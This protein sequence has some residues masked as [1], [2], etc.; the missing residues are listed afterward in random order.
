MWG[1]E[2]R[3]KHLRVSHAL[4]PQACYCCCCCS[5]V[6]RALRRSLILSNNKQ[7]KTSCSWTSSQLPTGRRRAGVG[8][9]QARL[10]RISPYSVVGCPGSPVPL[11]V[12]VAAQTHIYNI[13]ST[14]QST[15]SMIATR[16]LCIGRGASRRAQ[17][18]VPIAARASHALP[19]LGTLKNHC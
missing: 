11:V 7:T 6:P 3:V 12:V 8:A 9:T 5:I 19:F 10:S 18:L 13:N 15:T 17:I 16:S 4:F 2:V 14:S 1:K